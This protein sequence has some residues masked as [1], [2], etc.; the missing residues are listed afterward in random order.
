MFVECVVDACP[1]RYHCTVQ[2]MCDRGIACE[3]PWEWA[4]VLALLHYEE[5]IL[6]MLVS[7]AS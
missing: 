1:V 3:S 5:W 4:V 7:V 6:P 2:L